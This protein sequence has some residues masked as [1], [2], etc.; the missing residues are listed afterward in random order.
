MCSKLNEVSKAQC[1][2]NISE[3]DR[4]KVF[5]PTF[6]PTILVHMNRPREVQPN[7]VKKEYGNWRFGPET[8]NFANEYCFWRLVSI[9]VTQ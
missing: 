3:I 4:L 1:E 9:V 2:A 5:L 8:I 7:C 6:P